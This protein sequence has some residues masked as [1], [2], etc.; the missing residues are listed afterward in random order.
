MNETPAASSVLSTF[1]LS[2][3]LPLPAGQTEESIVAIEH[4]E[5]PF[6]DA[7][8]DLVM[9]CEI[10]EQLQ[11][12]PVGVFRQI[13]RI[14]KQAGSLIVTKPNVN[15]FE[16]VCRM[17]AGANTYDPYS[18]YGPYGRHSRE[19]NQHELALLL[20]YCGFDIDAMFSAD[21]HE[22]AADRFFPTAQASPLVKYRE[23]DLGQYLFVRAVN[24]RP[25]KVKRPEW[26]YR[27]YPLGELEP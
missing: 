3:A 14:L 10:I 5:F 25:A 27:S 19:Y 9:R 12:D 11:V 8:F 1:P 18:G 20:D 2:P 4:D 17:I 24:I 6:P 16:N 23:Q 13:K 15:R 26:L 7:R 22:N 21:V